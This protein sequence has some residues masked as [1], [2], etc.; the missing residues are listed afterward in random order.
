MADF[1]SYSHQLLLALKHMTAH[2]PAMVEEFPEKV[3]V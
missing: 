1:G 3:A 2:I